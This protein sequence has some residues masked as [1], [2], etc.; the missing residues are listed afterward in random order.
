MLD[1]FEYFSST[2]DTAFFRNIFHQSMK[3]LEILLEI[4]DQDYGSLENFYTM[5]CI[6]I[7]N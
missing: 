3:I 1:K 2:Q 6:Q 7:E 4:K 5:K